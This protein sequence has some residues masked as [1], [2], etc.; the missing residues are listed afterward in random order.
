MTRSRVLI[1]RS[2]TAAG[3]YGAAVLGFLG[4][5]LAARTLGPREYGLL[6]IVLAAT[7]F[8]QMLLDLTVEEAV[9]KYGF[10]YS[11]AEQW[12]KLRR[13]FGRAIQFKGTGGVAA[14]VALVALAPLAKGLFG[15]GG[16]F[17]PLL[18][19]A[20]LPLAQAPEGLA[21]A[22]IILR[23]RYDVRSA[24]LLLSM[25]LR[26]AALAVGS[27]Y[28]VTEA[29]LAVVLAQVVATGAVSL[30]G[31]IAF[32]R[33][34]AAPA[35]PITGD[36]EDIVSFVVQSS[37]ATGIVSA[38][39]MLSPLLLGIVTSPAQVAFFRV[40]QAPQQGFAALSAPARIILLT[41]Q[42]R[43]WER[44]RFDAVLAGV[45]RYTIGATALMAL[46]L[47]PLL[48]FMPD[49]IRLLYKAQYLPATNAARIIVL[50]AGLQL[51]TG[52]TKSLPVSI[53]RPGLRIVTH[54]IETA[55]LIPLVVVLGSFWHAAG[56]AGA[57]LV[58]TCAFAAVWAVA[59]AR[60]K[61]GVAAAAVPGAA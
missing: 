24:L 50:A 4:Q 6:A 3:F 38:R 46:M 8:F 32:R 48:W 7:G 17:V 41:E 20:A 13:L 45:R 58:S 47:P 39:A 22:A 25:A 10:R 55:V 35:E 1:R 19:A 9:I 34:P 36:R 29:V 23:G 56:A 59:L 18:I 21:G 28:G 16:L 51:V 31:L 26:L 53:G 43:D 57:V 49:V 60:V 14:G 5:L 27:R 15:A 40:A 2:A 54:G 37:I 61:R 11:T 33:F 52:W 42:T 12:G 30:A 44:G